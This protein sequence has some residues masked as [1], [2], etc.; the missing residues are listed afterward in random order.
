[1]AIKSKQLP[2]FQTNTLEPFR[3]SGQPAPFRATG[4]GFFN[5][6]PRFPATA[7]NAN[8]SLVN[9][10]ATQS[11]YQKI[12]LFVNAI[13]TGW[14]LTGE[15][16]QAER[17]RSFYPRNLAQDELSIEGIV[18]SQYEYD[19]LVEFI[20]HHQMSQ[21]TPNLLASAASTDGD[22][23]YPGI[24]FTLVQPTSSRTSHP[25]D[26]FPSPVR[27]MVVVTDAPQAG[28]KKGQ[29]AGIPFQLTCKVTYDY[30][31]SGTQLDNEI[32]QFVA[33]TQVFGSASNP[34]PSDSINQSI[35]VSAEITASNEASAG[36]AI[37]AIANDS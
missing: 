17:S 7:A 27:Y 32:N 22:D 21:L 33:V 37:K 1:M 30:M 3:V 35:T 23:G 19:L 12:Y 20:L 15:T 5:K 10:A 28:A 29:M 8:A 24:I 34:S 6:L 26:A 2:P 18:A 11:K 36:S 13:E 9:V 14:T 31:Q 4:R 25:L 16:V